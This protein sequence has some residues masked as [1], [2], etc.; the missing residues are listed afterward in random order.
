VDTGLCSFL[1]SGEWVWEGQGCN[2]PAMKVSL[3]IFP[4]DTRRHFSSEV[5]LSSWDSPSG[6]TCPKW[7]GGNLKYPQYS[8]VT[9]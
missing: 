3:P 6:S 9:L 2:S 4:C 5:S 7:P 1:E 8:P